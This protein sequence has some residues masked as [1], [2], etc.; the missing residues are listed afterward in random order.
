MDT[1]ES[2]ILPV[3]PQK[4]MVMFPGAIT[5]LFVVSEEGLG[6]LETALAGDKRLFLTFQRDTEKGDS[7]ERDLAEVGT[8]AEI[9][10]VLRV[11]DGSAKV[12]A[13]GL[14]AAQAVDY[15]EDPEGT[16]ALLVRL[17][18]SPLDSPTAVA[19]KRTT[20]A[21]FETYSSLSDNVPEDLFYSIKN[22]D[23]PLGLVH[24][25]AN[26]TGIKLAEKQKILESDEL[27]E[28]FLLLNMNLEK[29]NQLLELEDQIVTQVKSRIGSSQREYFLS[30]QLKI[31]EKEL[32]IGRE[33]NPDV[34]ELRRAILAAGLTGD[35]L[36]KAERELRRLDRMSPMSPEATVSR[37]W[38]EWL[39]EVPW[40]EASEDR[41]DLDEARRILDAD[42]YGLEKVKERIIEYL[43]VVSLSG[44]IR[45][46]ILCLVGPPGVGKTSLARSIARCIDRKFVRISLGGVR[47]EAEIRG[48]RRTY[49][50]AMPGK[51][52]QAVKKGGTVNPVL[53]L[54]EIDKMSSD[55]RGDPASALLEVLDPEQNQAFNDHYLEVDYDLS[56]VMFITTANTT[57]GIPLPLQDRMEIIRLSGYTNLEKEQIA[58]RHLVPKAVEAN[59]LK[60]SKVRFERTSLM[61]LLESY[62]REAGVR[63]LERELHAVCRKIAMRIVKAGEKTPPVTRVTGAMI[64]ELLG[65][66]RHQKTSLDQRREVGNALGLAW[67]EVGGELLHVETRAMSGKGNLMLTG[68]LGEVM[69]ESANAALS[70]IRSCAEEL[71]I[72]ADFHEK[73]DIHVHLPEG[74]IPKDGPS[75]GITLATSLVSSLSGRPVRQDV[76]MTG[77]ITLRGKVL[78]IGGLK[79]KALAAYRYGIRH[80]LF[81]AENVPDLEEV[82]AEARRAIRFIPV[83][84]L[85]EVLDFAL[86]DPKPKTKTPARPRKAT[87]GSSAHRS[88]ARRND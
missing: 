84:T 86:S 46:P 75:A 56:R 19:Y 36:A 48:H 40:K 66:E 80:V 22:L 39:T 77:E 21:L 44:G 34:E 12:L 38:V 10:Q 52:I 6:A 3:L 87:K 73:K 57:A 58:R 45:G 18:V 35:A 69:K 27:E 11:P 47:D 59:G 24:A 71:G 4:D 42:H 53:L 65:P 15:I 54:D 28:K 33:D 5:P 20:T 2:A 60:K 67:T 17:E 49:I 7:K 61:A 88:A 83:R 76:A 31:I 85:G 68:T 64:R 9:L 13:E 8:V 63:G 41:I 79:E 78:K 50:G 55:M 32:G 25:V 23:D 82:P 37:T 1:F 30:E 43:A 70:Y 74:A 72:D 26:Y 81:P 14:Y 29:E 51:I 16:Q 62:T